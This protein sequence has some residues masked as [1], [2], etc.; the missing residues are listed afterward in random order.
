[1]NIAPRSAGTPPHPPHLISLMTTASKTRVVAD[2][3]DMLPMVSI[4]TGG[5][6]GD[7]GGG[8]DEGGG[9]AEE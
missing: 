7:G 8:G 3:S 2:Y 9:G 6:M 5:V 1:M 4:A